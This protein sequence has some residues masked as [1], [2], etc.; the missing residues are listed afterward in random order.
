M[1]DATQKEKVMTRTIERL[2]R[3]NEEYD[4]HVTLVRET[5]N[6]ANRGEARFKELMAINFPEQV[7]GKNL[8]HKEDDI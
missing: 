8:L 3:W 6:V 7:K 5:E 1:E 4:V 2:H